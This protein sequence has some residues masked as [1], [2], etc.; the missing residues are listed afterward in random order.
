[1]IEYKVDAESGVPYLMEIN[2]RFWGSLQLAIDAGVDFPRLLLECAE[3][4]APL[5]PAPYRVGV[6]SRWFWGTIDHLVARRHPSAHEGTSVLRVL[7][8]LLA[9]WKPN[10]R[11][12]IFC[13]DDPRPFL[14]ETL[15][16]LL[17]QAERAEANS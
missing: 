5:A 8:D 14:R 7:R 1:M 17:P 13:L 10:D 6:R 12:E 9:F 2:G 3:D 4:R 11:E 16:W 15:Q